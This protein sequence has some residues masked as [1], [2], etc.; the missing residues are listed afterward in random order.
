[1]GRYLKR[2]IFSASLYD[3]EAGF[4]MCEKALPGGQSGYSI[5][6]R[7][8]PEPISQAAEAAE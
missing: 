4:F 8:L 5:V 6:S 2:N 1:M 3:Q 7:R